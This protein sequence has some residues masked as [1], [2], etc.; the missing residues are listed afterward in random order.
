MQYHTKHSIITLF[1]SVLKVLRSPIENAIKNSCCSV[2]SVFQHKVLWIMTILFIVIGISTPIHAATRTSTATGGTWA[3][4]STWVGGTAPATTDNVIIAT[5]GTGKVTIGSS[6]SCA[7]LNVNSG[8][9]LVFNNRTLTINGNVT[10]SGTMT[11][12][13]GRITLGGTGIL[14]NSGTI[15]YTGTGRLTIVGSYINTGTLTLLATPVYFA[16]T[17]AA[18]STVDGFTTTG[19]VSYGRTAGSTTFTGG[20]SAAAFTMAASGGTLNMGTNMNH[21]FT[22]RVTLTSGTMNGGSSSIN[23]NLVGTAWTNTTGV[24]NAGSSTVIFGGAGNQTLTGTLTTTFN[25][26]TLKGSGTKT[27]T[28]VPIINGILSME[29][30]ASCATSPSYGVASTIQYKGSAAKTTGN[31]FPSTFSGTGGLIIDQGS[32]AVTLGANK[33]AFNSNLYIKTGTFNTSTFT[34]NRATAGGSLTLDAGTSLRIGGTLTLPSN[35]TTHSISPTST[36]EYYGTNQSI[37]TLNSSQS[38]GNVLLSTSGTKTFPASSLSIAG[39]LTTSGTVVANAGAN[40]QIGGL[41]TIGSGTTFSAG[42]YIH[43]LSGNLVRTG[44]FNAGTSTI[45]LAASGAQ[46]IS[47]SATTFY[48]LT[49]AGSG[50]KTFTTRPTVTNV[51]SMEGTADASTYATLGSASTIQYKGTAS[52]TTGVEFPATFAGSGGLIIDQGVGN[53][54]TLDANK[55]AFNGNI[56]VVTGTLDLST[57]TINRVGIG[58]T[59]ALAAGTT[60]KIGG[61]NALPTNFSNFNFDVAS[62]VLFN[63]SSTQSIGGLASITFGNLTLDNPLNTTLSYD[64]TVN[65]VLNLTNGL[66]NT[67]SNTL[68]IGCS[69][70]IGNASATRY[71]NGKLARVYCSTGTQ[72]FPIGKGGNYRPLTLT[73][74]TLTGSSTV[75]VEQMEEILPGTLPDDILPFG[76]R[77]WTIAQSGGSDY[78][79]HLSLDGTGWSPSS[80]LKMLK[81]DGSTN[82]YYGVTTP[83]YSNSTAFNSFGNFGLGELNYVTWLGL[84]ADWFSG[85]NWTSETPPASSDEI[86]IPSSLPNDPSIGGTSPSNDFSVTSSGTLQIEDG[87]NLTLE[88]GPLL[89]FDAGANV[90]TGVGSKII[91]KS[92]ARYLNLSTS[93]PTLEVQRELTDSTGWRM[94]SSPVNTT[95]SDMFKDPMVTQG[96]TGATFSDLAPNLLWWDETDG[97]TSLQS[98]RKPSALSDNM[99]AGRGYFHYAFNGAGRLNVDGSPSG[100]NYSD[101]LP[102]TMSVTGVSN[103]NGIGTF[104]Y[105]LTYTGKA[106]T[107]TPS[108]T[109]TIYYDLNALDEGWNLI[110]NPTASSLDWDAFGW[111]KTNMDNS[112]YVWD[113]SALGGNGDFLT[114]NGTTGTLGSGTIAPFQAF[115]VHATA[116]TT[117]S[118]TNA[119]KTSTAGTFLRNSETALTFTIPITLTVGD[120]QTT[121]FLTFSDKGVVGPDNWDAYRL[122]SMSDTWLELYT[123]SSPGFVSPLVINHLPLLNDELTYIPMYCNAQI[124]GL[125]SKTDYTLTW[126]LPDNW[127]SDWKIGLQDHLSEQVIPM[128]EQSTYSYNATVL[129]KASDLTGMNLLPKNPVRSF[130]ETHLLRSTALPPL[131]ILISKGSDINYMAPQPQLLGNY[132]NPFGKMTTI[133][134]SLP[135]KEK[136]TI[137]VY[138]AR[139]RKIVQLADGIYNAGISEIPW[140]TKNV[141]P[142]MYFLRFTSGGIVETKKAILMY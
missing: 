112:I 46:S 95:F 78:T 118:F 102:T 85:S 132:P 86:H 101:T 75:T 79:F 52:R 69:G 51:F 61:A 5:T 108:P 63:G 22:G 135:Q 87:A 20:V 131:S 57:F 43:S 98:W 4:G 10:N 59:M 65:G 116:T 83:N 125:G 15:T 66:L 62:T 64:Q 53:S 72:T 9:T 14:T 28:K 104:D 56:T 35:F 138:S 7:S 81:G 103:Y 133:R 100:S 110:G 41:L 54:I 73:Y 42:S 71:V 96:F 134:F 40:L 17:N 58:G 115:W 3:T 2:V 139:G 39:T 38:Y 88:N 50:T 6:T 111:T 126:T 1:I 70:S 23:A 122:E 13:T 12:S 99:V 11:I 8:S 44:T 82:A 32:F 45:A 94:L 89:T 92:N 18:A 140:H 136:V 31:E 29:G 113:P 93:T 106:S 48:N 55:T 21:T 84:T 16:G 120:L 76:S 107:Q 26:F 80:Y 97:G 119:V 68:T 129:T 105:N 114:W 49:L 19:L 24:F 33:T 60:L 128:N 25:N 27:L 137:E 109:D 117:L 123:T 34:I 37:A 124:N 67:G 47:G 127:P 130:T 74:S 77:Y 121:S 142:G 36:I 90:S 141:A 91:L 30:T